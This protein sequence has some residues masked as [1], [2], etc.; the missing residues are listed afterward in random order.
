MV[1]GR[2]QKSSAYATEERFCSGGG[3]VFGGWCGESTQ[4]D[5]WGQF[6][7]FG[8]VAGKPVEKFAGAFP[9]RGECSVVAGNSHGAL[10]LL[11]WKGEE[12]K[13]AKLAPGYFH[14]ES[15]EFAERQPLVLGLVACSLAFPVFLSSKGDGG[16]AG[17][18][19]EDDASSRQGRGEKQGRSRRDKG[20][21]VWW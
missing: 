8:A 1:N 13:S 20:S 18:G 3:D 9:I 10:C 16:N 4:E 17:S 5:P 21:R 15:T 6:H 11:G 2:V 7:S 12:K 19:A 14:S